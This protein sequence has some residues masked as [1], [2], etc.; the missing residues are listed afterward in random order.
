MWPGNRFVERT[1]NIG[2]DMLKAIFIGA[3]IFIGTIGTAM[4]ESAACQHLDF[5]EIKAMKRN[6]L[7]MAYCSATFNIQRARIHARTASK[8]E[9]INRQRA[10]SSDQATET[11]RNDRASST[12]Q[13]DEQ[14]CFNERE[15]LGRALSARRIN[16]EKV[17]QE[18]PL[19]ES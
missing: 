5:A 2:E 15:R 14:N 3:G 10:E 7:E 12:A 16:V 1:A 4:A 9:G 18:C 8:L 6:D 17:N 13:S 19:D 11:A